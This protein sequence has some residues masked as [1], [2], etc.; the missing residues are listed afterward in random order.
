[1]CT[2][3]INYCSFDE[4]ENPPEEENP[5]KKKIEWYRIPSVQRQVMLKKKKM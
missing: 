1:M 5:A 3:M 4:L 2:H